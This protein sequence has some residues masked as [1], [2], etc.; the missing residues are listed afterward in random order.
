MVQL[1]ICK[2]DNHIHSWDSFASMRTTRCCHM[3]PLVLSL[4]LAYSTRSLHDLDTCHHQSSTARSPSLPK[5]PLDLVNT[6][7][8]YLYSCTH[9][10]PQVSVTHGQFSSFSNLSVMPNVRPSPL[11]VLGTNLHDLYLHRRPPSLCFTTAH[12]KPRDTLHTSQLMLRLVN[13]KIKLII[14]LTIARH[15][16]TL[17]SYGHI[18]TTCLHYLF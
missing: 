6:V 13:T 12:H 9:R 5:P 15:T 7:Y 11:V 10:C 17:W 4:W 18:S 8:S 3:P 1:K 2:F 16:W 14:S